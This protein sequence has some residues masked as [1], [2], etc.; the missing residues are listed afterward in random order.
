MK[1]KDSAQQRQRN[2][3]DIDKLERE[4]RPNMS[5]LTKIIPSGDEWSH[6]N[7]KIDI[8]KDIEDSPRKDLFYNNA[9][10]RDEYKVD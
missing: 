8:K 7:M 3:L 9:K 2:V 4:V 6:E 10:N 5:V 1:I